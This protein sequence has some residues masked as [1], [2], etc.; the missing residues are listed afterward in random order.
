MEEF[1]IGLAGKVIGITGMHDKIRLM[2]E[3]YIIK[4]GEKTDINPGD[5]LSAENALAEEDF[6]ITVTQADIDFERQKSEQEAKAHG[7]EPQHYSDAY[8]ETLSAYRKI[9]AEMPAFDTW[10]MHGAV[11][12]VGDE[13][14]IFTAPS[15]VGKTTHLK[16]WLE[17]IPG[18]YVI[19][20]DKPL[21]Q[22]QGNVCKVCGTPWAG[23]EGL[24]ENK[25]VPLRAICFLERGPVNK[26]KKISSAEAYPFMLQQTYRAADLQTMKKTLELLGRVCMSVPMYLLSCNM[27]AEAAKVACERI[28]GRTR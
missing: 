2:C 1:R 12:G 21:L 20:G 14:V 8:L 19:N 16:L 28:Y 27:D 26:I 9:A 22:W 25:I 17:N 10:L 13:A 6:H 7:I 18:S 5:Q 24:Q 4:D 23:K 3:D 11:V 15:G